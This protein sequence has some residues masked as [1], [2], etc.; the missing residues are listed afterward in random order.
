MIGNIYAAS[1]EPD[2]RRL[3]MPRTRYHLYYTVRREATRILI[4]SVWHSHRGQGPAM[5]S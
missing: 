2:M 5:G 4:H 3:L 1:P